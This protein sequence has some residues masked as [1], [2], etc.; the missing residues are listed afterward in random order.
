MRR[1]RAHF[2]RRVPSPFHARQIIFPRASHIYS[3]V[4]FVCTRPGQKAYVQ[5]AYLIAGEETERREFGSLR[6][7]PDDYPKYVISASPLLKR[8]DNEG[9]THIHLREFLKH[10]L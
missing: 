6:L 2:S 5:V 10:G 7:I 9:V 8:S 4:D 1:A 3:S